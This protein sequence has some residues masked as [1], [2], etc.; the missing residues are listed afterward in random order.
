[1]AAI[2]FFV[3][4]GN[5]EFSNNSTTPKKISSNYNI[6]NEDF[7]GNSNSNSISNSILNSVSNNIANV[8]ANL[9]QT[10]YQ[11]AAETGT[12]DSVAEYQNFTVYDENENEVSLDSFSGNPAFILFW[13]DEEDSREMLKTLNKMYSSY[14]SK[15]TF[16]IVTDYSEKSS[17]SQYV[18]ENNIQIPIYFEQNSSASQTYN[19]SVYP[20]TVI[21]D[22]NN[23]IINVKEGL[24]DEDSILANL[25]ILSENY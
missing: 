25:D 1:V 4:S 2:A 6:A 24:Q 13:K 8:S 17:A 14:S 19:I 15:V 9:N 10:D 16:L 7:V 21:K 11:T 20:S 18:S 5:L 23:T 22:K 12:L 3:I